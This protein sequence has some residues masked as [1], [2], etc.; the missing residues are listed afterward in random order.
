M[1]DDYNNPLADYRL[2]LFLYFIILLSY[3]NTY[4]FNCKQWLEYFWS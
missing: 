1:I 3:Q 4:H 2:D